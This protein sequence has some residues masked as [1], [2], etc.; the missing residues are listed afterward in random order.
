MTSIEMDEEN[1]GER[2]LRGDAEVPFIEKHSE[3]ILGSQQV[4]L[5]QLQTYLDSPGG[6][7]IYGIRDENRNNDRFRLNLSS[8]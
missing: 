8:R 3:E 2:R 6:E 5:T 7:V 1:K 4:V